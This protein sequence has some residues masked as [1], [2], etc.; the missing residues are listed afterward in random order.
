M[1]RNRPPCCSP[2]QAPVPPPTASRSARR[3]RE[4]CGGTPQAVPPLFPGKAIR[5]TQAAD[6]AA[7][8]SPCPA[9]R[10]VR[11]HESQLRRSRPEG[12]PLGCLTHGVGDARGQN[13]R[14]VVPVQTAP[15]AA[16]ED[17]RAR[18]RL[19]SLR[20]FSISVEM[21]G[22]CSDSGPS[23]LRRRPAPRLGRAPGRP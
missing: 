21:T 22:N 13:G 4:R 5:E 23:P 20:R 6:D 14:D 15:G 12:C 17:A 9:R 16:L 11:C 19:R 3:G 18:D 10:Q 2:C 7:T 8:S 1:E